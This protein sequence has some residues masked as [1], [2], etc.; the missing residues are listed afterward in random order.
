MRE[1]GMTKCALINASLVDPEK[2]TQ[3]P[4]GVLVENGVIVDFGAHVTRAQVGDAQVIDCGGDVVSPGL[5]DM[6]V[7]VGEPGADR[8]DAVLCL[9]Q[10]AWAW[11]RRDANYGLPVRADRIEGWI[12][13]A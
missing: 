7:F 5:I 8:L 2:G 3:S 1:T 6:R 9:V 10:A 13:G 11:S 4:G 12:V